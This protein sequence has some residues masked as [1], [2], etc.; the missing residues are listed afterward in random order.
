MRCESQV[1]DRRL[2]KSASGVSE[3][4]SVVREP[5]HSRRRY[6]EVEVAPTNRDSTGYCMLPGREAMQGRMLLDPAASFRTGEMTASEWLQ[7]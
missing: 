7:L 1:L 2:V 6:W 4:R 3:K 5:P